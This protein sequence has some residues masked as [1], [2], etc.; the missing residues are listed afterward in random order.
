[1]FYCVGRPR[2]ARNCLLPRFSASIKSDFSYLEAYGNALHYILKPSK[3]YCT[4]R[5]PGKRMYNR[6]YASAV[7]GCRLSNDSGRWVDPLT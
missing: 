2:Y 6:T 5:R 4:S 7:I 3:K 1:M